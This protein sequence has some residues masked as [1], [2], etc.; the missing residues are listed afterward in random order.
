MPWDS[1]VVCAHTFHCQVLY[2]SKYATDMAP[3]HS[4]WNLKRSHPLGC[5]PGHWLTFRIPCKTK[6]HKCP[7]E[8]FSI[9]H[10]LS[11]RLHST[12]VKSG[13][14]CRSRIWPRQSGRTRVPAPL[15]PGDMCGSGYICPTQA[16]TWR[17]KVAP[18][19]LKT[20]I[21]G[22]YLPAVSSRVVENVW[23]RSV[24]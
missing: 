16:W 10:S 4:E 6:E 11:G 17:A 20:S 13:N 1:W 8:M 3:S 12:Y 24:K 5:F 23:R 14:S 22:C 18:P 19:L 15:F 9:P 7:N 21:K 2:V